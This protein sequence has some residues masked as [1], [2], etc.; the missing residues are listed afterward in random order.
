[1]ALKLPEKYSDYSPYGPDYYLMRTA[2]W[3]IQLAEEDELESVQ[4]GA[5]D[6]F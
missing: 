1:M 6:E 3:S 2:Y 5:D 4:G